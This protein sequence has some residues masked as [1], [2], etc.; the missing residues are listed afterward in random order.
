MLPQA[1]KHLRCVRNG[2]LVLISARTLFSRGRA[3]IQSYINCENIR[4]YQKLIAMS[5]GDPCRDE[6][7]HQNEVGAARVER[8]TL[9]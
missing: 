1:A 5:E 9:N 4:R 6:A 2:R 3:E 8:Q 7:R